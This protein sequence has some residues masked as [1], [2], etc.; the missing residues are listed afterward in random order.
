MEIT[1]HPFLTSFAGNPMRY[2]LTTGSGGGGGGGIDPIDGIN[3]IVEID[4]S[5]IDPTPDHAI[6]I[7]FMGATR[8]F[9]LKN[10]P[11]TKDHLPIADDVWTPAEWAQA[12]Y[13]YIVRDRQ[14]TDSYDITNDVAGTIVLTAKTP[15]TQYDWSSGAN[16]VVGVTV[17][18]TQNGAAGTSGTTGTV[19]GVLMSV[20][21]NPMVLLGQDYKPLDATG[22]VR[23]EIQE[24]IYSTLL[25]LAQP[26]FKLAYGT[27]H[28]YMWADFFLKYLTSFCNRVDGV[29]QDRSYSEG[30]C[31]ALPGGLNREDLVA[32]NFNNTDYFNLT[33]TKKKFLT[34]APPSKITDKVETHSLFFAFQSPSYTHYKM[35]AH[36]YSGN[37]GET[38]DCTG[39]YTVTPWT[40]VE[41]FAGYA[42]LGLA[43]ELEGNVDRWEMYLVDDSDNVISDVRSFELDPKYYENTRYFRFRNSWGTYDSLRC[44]G[45]F[46][47]IVEHEREKVIFINNETET[48]Y[49]APG[50]YSMVKE[51]QSFKANTGWLAKDYLN[52]LRDFMLSTD[53]FEVEDARL[54]KCLLTSKKTSLFKDKE[55]NYSLAFEYE[56]AWDDFF[57]QGLE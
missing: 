4:F 31:Y 11:S 10:E 56:R 48:S 49:N 25:L 42:Q 36:I 6:E 45:V 16:T 1:N 12:C 47:N 43:A 2:L 32:N 41:F 40:V 35:K 21:K 22:S 26:R 33:A 57:F 18:T 50:A 28:H 14:L 53:I 51:A 34:W 29:Y 9:T 55:Y 20:Y 17:T 37:T 54:L 13:D 7:T 44:T 52:Y 38:I 23:F 30:Y 39:L 15:D 19:E 24:Y 8:T 27:A 3:S 5:D 46:E